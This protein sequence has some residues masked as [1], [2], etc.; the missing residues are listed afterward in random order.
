MATA[1]TAFIE[2]GTVTTAKEFLQLCSR[3]F[4]V[5][6]HDRDEPLS[7]DIPTTIEKDPHFE[8]DVI[9]AKE[10]LDEAIHETD[11]EGKL[12][13]YIAEC[14]T[15]Y[16]EAKARYD[17]LKE[18]YKTIR[19]G[20]QKWIPTETYKPIKTFALN[21]I[22]ISVKSL[23]DPEYLNKKYEEA[24]TYTVDYFKE[25]TLKERSEALAEAIKI[26][27][28]EDLSVEARQKFIDGLW[29]LLNSID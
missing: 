11:W 16:E 18:A 13:D 19:A 27:Q 21:Q 2:D 24:Q 4:G 7:P 10:F 5:Y 26:S 15:K 29:E 12:S 1:Y 22:D 3:Q 9:A 6:E 8:A 17:E 23:V 20:V 14:Q 25:K 28:K